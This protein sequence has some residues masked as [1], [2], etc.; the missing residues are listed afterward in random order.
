MDDKQRER[1]IERAGLLYDHVPAIQAATERQGFINDVMLAVEHG[2]PVQ[3]PGLDRTIA[4]DHIL[5]DFQ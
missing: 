3:L 5:K 4:P 1:V 2:E